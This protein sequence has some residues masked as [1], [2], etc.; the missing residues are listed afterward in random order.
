MQDHLLAPLRKMDS[1][2][3]GQNMGFGYE[4]DG[5]VL[6]KPQAFEDISFTSSSSIKVRKATRRARARA[7]ARAKA[8]EKRAKDCAKDRV[9]LTDRQTG[10]RRDRQRQTDRQ[11]DRQAGRQAGRQTDRQPCVHALPTYKHI[12]VQTYKHTYIQTNKHTYIHTYI[13]TG[14]GIHMLQISC[15]EP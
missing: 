3:Y 6:S 2:A 5:C 14:T 15:Y 11:T 9:L 13:G 10:R 12:N 7:K 4:M 8:K 1:G